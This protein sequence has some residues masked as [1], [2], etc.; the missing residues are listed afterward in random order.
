MFVKVKQTITMQRTQRCL[1][2]SL[3]VLRIANEVQAEHG[4]SKWSYT[5][6][7]LFYPV[8]AKQEKSVFLR[9]GRVKS[10]DSI[11]QRAS[12]STGTASM[13]VAQLMNLIFG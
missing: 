11:I 1:L 10:V 5:F 2:A 4:S 13:S 8:A 3:L 9:K 7:G 6:N 12:C